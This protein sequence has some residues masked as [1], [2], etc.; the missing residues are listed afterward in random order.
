MCEDAERGAGQVVLPRARVLNG[1]LQV[2]PQHKTHQVLR[3][4]AH[5][6]RLNT[7]DTNIEDL[8]VS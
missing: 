4:S 7:G 8:P 5:N 1:Q 6:K 2:T 3:L